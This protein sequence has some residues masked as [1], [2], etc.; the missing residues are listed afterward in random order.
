[1][2]LFAL[3]SF[4]YHTIDTRAFEGVTASVAYLI[5]MN[6]PTLLGLK[7]VKQRRS[8]EFYSLFINGLEVIGYTAII[9]FLGGFRA[10]YVTPMYAALITY[11]GVVAPRRIPLIIATFCAFAFVSMATLEHFGFIPHQ[12]LVL[13]GYD[14]TTP[15]LI[16]CTTAMAGLL[17]VVAFIAGYTG[18]LLKKARDRL[19]EKNFQLQ[20]SER[21]KSEFWPT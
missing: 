21:L 18:N 19:K 5:L 2:W 6:I 12:N 8:Y 20:E 1:M 9:Y 16:I 10:T 4:F 15:V 3:V 14:F 17:Y 13:S 7:F 11:L